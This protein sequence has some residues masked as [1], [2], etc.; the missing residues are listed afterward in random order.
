[1]RQRFRLVSLILVL[2]P[3]NYRGFREET[4]VWRL[5][6]KLENILSWRDVI[7]CDLDFSSG[8]GELQSVRLE[9]QQDLLQPLLVTVQ[10]VI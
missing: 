9:I 10:P 3:L 4:F 2:L 1:M 5:V 6:V 7:D 8:V